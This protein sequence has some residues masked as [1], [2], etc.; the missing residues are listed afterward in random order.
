LDPRKNHSAPQAA[1]AGHSLS[2][3]HIAP[4]RIR[5][6]ARFT[7]R[8]CEHEDPPVRQ[9][10]TEARPETHQNLIHPDKDRRPSRPRA[11]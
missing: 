1:L 10:A 9:T 2:T 4:E 7:P 5:P 6:V 3:K 8:S 11:G